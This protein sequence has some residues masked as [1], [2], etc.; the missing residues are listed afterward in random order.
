MKRS[1]L[2]QSPFLDQR[3][4]GKFLGGISTKTMERWRIDGTGPVFRKLGRRVFYTEQDLL[5]WAAS[6]KRTST[7]DTR[8]AA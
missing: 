1:T 2:P 8:P 4:A 7:S 6:Q 3:A 5:E